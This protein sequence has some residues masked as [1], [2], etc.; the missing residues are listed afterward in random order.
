MSDVKKIFPE[1][2]HSSQRKDRQF[3]R[4]SPL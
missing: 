3:H 2:L 1:G 4:G